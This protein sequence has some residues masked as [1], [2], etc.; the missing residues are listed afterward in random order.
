MDDP[1]QHTTLNGTVDYINAL[2]GLCGHAQHHLVFFENDFDA[3]G[4]NSTAR[5]DTLRT[6][7]LASPANRLYLLAHDT[8]QLAQ[9][10]PRL[11]LLLR[12]FS[13][14]L[15]IYATPKHLAHLSEPFAVADA[16]H[17]VRRFHFDDP[18]GIYAEHDAEGARMLKSRF[19]EMWASSHA[20]VSADTLGL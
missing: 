13:H 8:R 17:Y 5:H 9:S 12:Q 6:F 18:R 3:C 1:L 19:E 4:F 11:L 20:A 10:C 16:A 2:D 14:A 7:L 15:R